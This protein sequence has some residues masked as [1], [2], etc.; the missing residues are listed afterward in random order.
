MD[1]DNFSDRHYLFAEN[2]RGG[3]SS[4][5]VHTIVA[6]PLYYS[7]LFTAVGDHSTRFFYQAET[8]LENN[9]L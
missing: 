8:I 1:M 7:G 4:Y 2:P 3:I 5:C 6:D 9:I